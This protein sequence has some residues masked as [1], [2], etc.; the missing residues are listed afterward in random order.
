MK[1]VPVT[2]QTLN[3]VFDQAK[4]ELEK[5]PL[6]YMSLVDGNSGKWGMARLWR[7][8]MASTAKFMT[9]NGCIMPLMIKK[10]GSHYGTRDFN[11]DD[12]HELFTQKWLY[13][14]VNG[15]RLSWSK[16]GRDGMRPATKGER[17]HA[18]LQ[19]EIWA[20]DR[21]IILFK[22]RDSEYAKLE[23]EQNK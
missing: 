13:V 16:S 7:A 5:S 3:Q 15:E 4:T 1:D 8:W 11:A 20:T 21:G 14:D 10:D 22:P 6:M 9:A 17:F 18:M 12:A 2:I 19:H 23:E